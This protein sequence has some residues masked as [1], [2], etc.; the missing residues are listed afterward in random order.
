MTKGQGLQLKMGRFGNTNSVEKQNRDFTNSEG[1]QSKLPQSR[2][3]KIMT[4]LISAIFAAENAGP[5]L[6][7]RQPGT[8]TPS[9]TDCFKPAALDV[10]RLPLQ[11][12]VQ[13]LPPKI[14]DVKGSKR[15]Q[16]NLH[17][18]VELKIQLRDFVLKT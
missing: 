11:H 18:S 17:L 14:G 15:L 4:Q 6:E 12:T 9:S 5:V 7:S 3:D 2:A 16:S 10:S 13:R 8:G 1:V